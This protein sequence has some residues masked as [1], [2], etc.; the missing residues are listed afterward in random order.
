MQNGLSHMKS[1]LG[2]AWSWW[3]GELRSAVPAVVA[4]GFAE[5]R[6]EVV[7]HWTA[8]QVDVL[9]RRGK[10]AQHLGQLDPTAAT[11]QATVRSVL[12]NVPKRTPVVIA[13]GDSYVL[14]QRAELPLAAE[15]TLSDVV[16]FELDRLTPFA[17]KDVYFDCRIV[18]RRPDAQKLDVDLYLATR[19]T[20]DAIREI[21]TSWGLAPVR[22]DMAS[23]PEGDTVGIHLM[24]GPTPRPRRPLARTVCTVLF[25]GTLGLAGFVG[26]AHLHTKEE[27]A[28]ALRGQLA[29]LRA[30]VA[31]YGALE[32]AASIEAAR[33][34]AVKTKNQTPLATEVLE[35]VTRRLPERSWLIYYRLSG[36]RLTLSG[37]SDAAANL[38]SLFEAS[39]MFLEAEFAE[40]IVQDP[41]SG[42]ERFSLSLR[43]TE[44]PQS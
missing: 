9:L 32:D 43:L 6:P 18:R 44:G 15:K 29:A 35:E 4:K 30:E 26:W 25:V 12:G 31:S 41:R 5:N 2:T 16:G 34:A 27:V 40:P 37:S 36:D 19:E 10:A 21:C 1:G 23:G 3:T 17:F 20:V 13:L 28:T 14:R 39:P 24:D 7:L 38:I 42:R 11:D 33:L 22:F 8:N